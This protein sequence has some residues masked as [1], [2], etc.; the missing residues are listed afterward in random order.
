M[1]QPPAGARP[2]RKHL[3]DPGNPRPMNREPMS[4][5]RVQKWVL[6]TLAA[7]TI[8]HLAIGLVVAAAFA[9]RVDAQVGLLVIGAAF[10]VIAV[11]AALVIHQHR[12]L[13]GW[14]ALGLVPSVVGA[15]VIL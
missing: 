12:L 6:S 7:T 9:E 13:S 5:G 15:F 4:I 1:T 11:L 8:M 2:V 14:L 10:G 3:M